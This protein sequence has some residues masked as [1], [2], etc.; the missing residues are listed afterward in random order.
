MNL[1]TNMIHFFGSISSKR[2]LVF[3]LY[4]RDCCALLKQFYGTPFK[5]KFFAQFPNTFYI[6]KSRRTNMLCTYICMILHYVWYVWYF[7]VRHLYISISRR[8]IRTYLYAMY[9]R[10]GY[11]RDTSSTCLWSL[12]RVIKVDIMYKYFIPI[13]TI[14]ILYVH[15][16]LWEMLA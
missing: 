9:I 11:V 1:Y 2:F 8:A 10:A 6:L 15:F 16:F 5:Y 4:P 12:W 3:Q 13:W 14:Y 7:A